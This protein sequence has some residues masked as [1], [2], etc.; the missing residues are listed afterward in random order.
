MV[1]YGG[2]GRHIEY[3]LLTDPNK[4]VYRTKLDKVLEYTYAI[5]VMCPKLAI[6]HLYLRVFSDRG[7]IYRWGAD[8]TGAVI[9]ATWITCIFL[10]SFMCRPFAYYW[11]RTIPGGRCLDQT[12]A[13]RVISIPNIVTDLVLLVLPLRPLYKLHVKLPVKIGL[14]ITF[15]V[16]SW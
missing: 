1:K 10:A 12:T 14:M 16:G 13:I 2:A 3:I 4:M 11:N 9:V 15:L 6:V 8:G 7:R 5:S